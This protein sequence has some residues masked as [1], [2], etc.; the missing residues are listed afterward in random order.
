MKRTFKKSLII[1]FALAVVMMTMV[2]PTVSANTDVAITFDTEAM[3]NASGTE[4]G[5]RVTNLYPT[6]SGRESVEG[7]HIKNGVIKFNFD[8]AMDESTLTPENIKV[9][10]ASSSYINPANPKFDANTM[11]WTYEPYEVTSTSYSISIADMCEGTMVHTVIFTSGVKTADGT[12]I[13]EVSKKFQTGRIVTTQG[14][15][16]KSLMDVAHKKDIKRYESDGTLST[17]ASDGTAYNQSKNNLMV[18]YAPNIDQVGAHFIPAK[19]AYVKIDLGNY[20]SI[21]DVVIYSAWG[22]EDFRAHKPV[23]VAYSNDPAAT[24]SSANSVGTMAANQYKSSGRLEASDGGRGYSRYLSPA[25]PFRARYIFL[26][27][28]NTGDTGE[29]ASSIKVIADVDTD[30]GELTAKKDGS[31]VSKFAG[32]GTYEV[33]APATENKA[34]S[35]GAYMIIAGF[36]A[37]GIVTKIECSEVSV[38]GGKVS[39]TTT[40]ENANTK[41]LKA[42]LIK[43]FSEPQMLTDALIL[44]AQ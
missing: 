10:L 36:D 8:Q 30:Y 21:Y 23:A 40:I 15:E 16:G 1:L 39:L 31:A 35:G 9:K 13:N 4:T 5:L 38:S 42:I 29:S 3:E 2:M 25:T 43:S 26:R 33:S 14:T 28:T 37:N 27:A 12:P 44:P 22:D 34:G 19:D 24:F 32:T 11:E 18:D 17:L 20:Y 7:Y 41:S 6:A